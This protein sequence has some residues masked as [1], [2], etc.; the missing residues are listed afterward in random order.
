MH[1]RA[2][3]GLWYPPVKIPWQIRGSL[4]Q[5]ESV[6]LHGSTHISRICSLLA[7]SLISYRYGIPSCVY[8]SQSPGHSNNHILWT[9]TCNNPNTKQIFTRM[10]R[11]ASSYTMDVEKM[12]V[13]PSLRSWPLLHSKAGCG[14][15]LK[16]LP[17]SSVLP[18]PGTAA[19]SP[20][21]QQCH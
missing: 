9:L 5:E 1:Y 11:N 13:V 4:P 21:V 12:A 6:R 7:M 10:H 20:H 14:D 18:S 19:G 17:T 8:Q 16:H 3:F 2:E 15:Y